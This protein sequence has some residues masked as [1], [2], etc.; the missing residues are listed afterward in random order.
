MGALFFFFNKFAC[1]YLSYI[2]IFVFNFLNFSSF[3]QIIEYNTFS[4]EDEIIEDV[5]FSV[6]LIFNL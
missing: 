5:I 6:N 1:L 4:D 3:F 2:F